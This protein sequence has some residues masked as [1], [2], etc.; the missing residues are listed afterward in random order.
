VSELFLTLHDDWGGWERR[1]GLGMGVGRLVDGG[2]P[3][4]DG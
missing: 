3:V 4:Q 1:G 2:L